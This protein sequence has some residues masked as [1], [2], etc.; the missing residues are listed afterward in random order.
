MKTTIKKLP[1][2]K[3]SIIYAD[4]PWSFYN[5]SDSIVNCTTHVGVRRPPYPCLGSETIKKIPVNTISD[6]NSILFIW[7]T[8]YHLQKCLEV[9]N[10]WGFKYK[11]VGF[12]WLKRTKN[13]NPVT[14]SGAY[15][16]KS[17]IELCLLATKGKKAHKL[18]T[19]HNIKA[20]VDAPR[21]AHS[22]KPD[23]VRD[24]IVELCGDISRIELFARK[25]YSGWDCWGN[26]I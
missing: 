21:E 25:K 23:V 8:D 3:Y 13:G 26:E 11:T 17:G 19:Q 1:N 4:P 5:D 2:K 16:C 15:T 24:R 12:A 22:K 14:F 10:A 18:V 7:T 9:I 20:L 6:E